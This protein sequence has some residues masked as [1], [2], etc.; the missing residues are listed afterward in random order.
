MIPTFRI[1]VSASCQ[2]AG[3]PHPEKPG[4]RQW[5][6]KQSQGSREISNV[7]TIRKRFV[8]G[9]R[10]AKKVQ[11]ASDTHIGGFL[12]DHGRADGIKTFLQQLSPMW[13]RDLGIIDQKAGQGW[14]YFVR[15]CT[16]PK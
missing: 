9:K 10:I 15:L 12:P 7:F 6:L 3:T 14:Y 4:S 1:H 11:R 5:A 13:Y 16:K 8:L 2:S